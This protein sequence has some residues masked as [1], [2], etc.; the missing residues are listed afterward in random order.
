MIKFLY[1]LRPPRSSNNKNE[2]ASKAAI[3]SSKSLIISSIIA[4]LKKRSSSSNM[5]NLS[6]KNPTFFENGGSLGVEVGTNKVP[7]DIQRTKFE[8]RDWFRLESMSSSNCINYSGA[9]R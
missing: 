8:D 3:T 5:C 9:K 4:P 7:T 6:N 1:W 2:G